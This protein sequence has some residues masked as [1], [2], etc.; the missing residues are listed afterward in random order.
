MKYPP[1][2]PRER[3][4]MGPGPSTVPTRILRA[5]GS[6]TLGH[7]DPQYIEYMDQCCQMLREVYQTQN[8]LTFPV[9]A[10]G[11]AGMEAIIVNLVEPGDEVIVCI[12]GV[13]GGR[14]KD[15]MERAGAVVHAI[16]VPWG[17]TFT[18]DQI[19]EVVTKFPKSKLLGIV[20]AETSTGAHQDV[21]GLGKIVHDAG[22]LL[23]VDAV[24]SLGGH[25]LKVDEWGIDAIYSGTQKC[26]SCPP[27]LS[28]VSFSARAI[29]RMDARKTK[30]QSWY[31][32]VSMLKNYYLGAGGRAYHHTAPINMV[33][34]LREALQIVLEEGLENRIARHKEMH[35][36]LRAGLEKLGL[37]YIPKNSLCSLNCVRTPEGIDE[38]AIRKRLLEEY[39][40]EI[41]GGLGVFAGKAWRIGLMGHGATRRNIN[42]LLAALQDCLA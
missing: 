18:N 20:Q 19:G 32:D 3:L 35:L 7:L 37:T 27:G 15:N 22:M 36:L 38:A 33:Y 13:F 8:P 39:D 42:T 16:E 25:E 28:P 11:M 23:A 26:L 9:S 1:L 10:T 12:N 17:E 14:M 29:E 4:L 40:I 31:L 2:A 5:L 21:S 34:A 24:T 6:P 30:V 41:G